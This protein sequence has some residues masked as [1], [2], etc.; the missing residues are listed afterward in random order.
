[1]EENKIELRSEPVQ[2]VMSKIPPG[3]LRYGITILFTIL[4]VLLIG[5]YCFKY[6]EKIEAEITLTSNH[7]PV[8][9]QAGNNGRLVDMYISDEQ[10][11]KKGDI[12]ALIDNVANPKDVFL[13]RK[14]L[15]RWKE[16]GKRIENT[17]ML[18]FRNLL[19]LGEIQSYYSAFITARQNYI[20]HVGET[21]LE[22][23]E[24][25]N[26]IAALMKSVA[27][28]EQKYLLVAP[29]DGKVFYMQP[30]SL[31]QPIKIEETLFVIQP[32]IEAKPLARGFLLMDLIGKLKVGQR[33]IVRL[34]GFSEQEYGIL[35][36][37]VTFV[38]PVPNADEKYVVEISLPNGLKTSSGKTLPMIE[39][40]NGTAD[41]VTKERSL[42]ERLIFQ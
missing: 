41:I 2:E 7:S 32:L 24:L 25:Y 19:E 4:L 8:Y 20:S 9:V 36:G 18:I 31:Q 33:A 16:Y 35:E 5:S 26:S 3:I 11:V 15:A 12:L 23:M 27:E 42:L 21:R 39:S 38:S 37:I 1:M 40:M 28:W 14:Q 34:S 10:I 6:P 30:W 13:L 17:D 22:E 29:I